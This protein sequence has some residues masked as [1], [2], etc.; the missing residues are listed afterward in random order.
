MKANKQ[1]REAVDFVDVR[2][3]GDGGTTYKCLKCGHT[4]EANAYNETDYRTMV[5]HAANCTGVKPELRAV[6]IYSSATTDI[7]ALNKHVKQLAGHIK[8]CIP[9]GADLS[10]HEA[11][12]LARVSMATDL[13]PFTGEVWYIPKK[14]PHIGIRG[15]R[16]K[17]KEQSLYSKSFRPMTPDEIT[18]HDVRTGVGDV[19]Y[20]CELYRHDLIKEAAQINQ[21]LGGATIPIKPTV[22]IGIW[23]KAYK[24]IAQYKDDSIPHGKSPAWVAKKRAEAD[25]LSQVYDVTI[26]L[27]F[28]DE[29]GEYLE[30]ADTEDAGWSVVPEDEIV[31]REAAVNAEKRADADMLKVAAMNAADDLVHIAAKYKSGELETPPWVEEIREKIR[32]DPKASEP[33]DRGMIQQMNVSAQ[34]K[35]TEAQF[36]AFVE[37]VFGKLEDMT[38]GGSRVL[39][40][41]INGKDFE[42]QVVSL[43]S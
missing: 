41:V 14:G 6:E 19:G 40:N 22:G 24:E 8:A 30:V 43:L 18:N 28:S 23:R 17:A 4:V 29:V 7:A 10:D 38:F 12:A 25:A 42:A 1:T 20:V 33:V 13:S 32:N 27:T 39:M 36:R 5:A 9:N 11:I 31:R 3:N 26:G 35:V 34:R 21:M 2:R 15:L 16:R 37:V